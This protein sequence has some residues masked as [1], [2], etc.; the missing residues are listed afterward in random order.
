[1]PPLWQ[2]GIAPRGNAIDTLN[3]ARRSKRT[4]RVS[5]IMADNRPAYE[6]GL[7]KTITSTGRL[8]FPGKRFRVTICKDL[9]TAEHFFIDRAG[10]VRGW[11]SDDPWR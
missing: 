3:V 8:G 1:M 5:T 4:V 10:P 9:K 6:G 11:N 2:H 7:T